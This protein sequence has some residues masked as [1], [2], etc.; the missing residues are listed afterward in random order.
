MGTQVERR[1]RRKKKHKPTVE[2]SDIPTEAEA[3]K[4]SAHLRRT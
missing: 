1:S 3:V 2:T 4:K